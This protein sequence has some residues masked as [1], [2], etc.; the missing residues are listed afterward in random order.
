MQADNAA[1][2]LSDFAPYFTARR[3]RMLDDP[4][5]MD[6][7]Y[8]LRFEVYCRDCTFLPA[9]DYP[10]SLEKDEYDPS[11]LHALAF[12]LQHEL[13]GYSRLVMPD[14]CGLFPWQS[15]CCELLPGAELPA[16]ELSAEVSRLMVHRHYRRRRGDVV[17]GASVGLAEPAADDFMERYRRRP[18]ILLSLYRQMYQH[19]LQH[20]IRYWYAAME[21][22]LAGALSMM[23]FP[24]Q[25]I[26]READYFGP[27]APYLAD[28]RKLEQVLEAKMPELLSWMQDDS[29]GA[30]SPAP[31]GPRN[32]N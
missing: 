16:P 11:S 21:R 9:E 8:R 12:N 19:S 28:L 30:P 2:E 14:A 10:D 1:M 6:L 15:H 25:A 32:P 23:G 26:G 7:A 31:A 22:G 27:V 17:Q 24:F 4:Q 29:V 20:G 5:A 18:Q 13:V 3:L